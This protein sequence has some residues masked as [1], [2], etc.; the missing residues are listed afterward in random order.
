[1]F[2]IYLPIFISNIIFILLSLISNKTK[3]L[4]SCLSQTTRLVLYLPVRFDFRYD[5]YSCRRLVKK[6]S[7]LASISKR[8]S[9]FISAHHVFSRC[10]CSSYRRLG[11]QKYVL[12]HVDL[13]KPV[14]FYI[15][16]SCL[17]SD[18]IFILLAN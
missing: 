9:Y 10:K 4:N 18:T 8:P 17:I 2:Y 6:I 3:Y 16:T 12:T 1:M 15:Y 14:M 5:L 13:K 11:K 7:E